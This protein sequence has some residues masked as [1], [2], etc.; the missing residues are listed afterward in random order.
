VVNL[1]FELFD[2]LLWCG[3]GI[4]PYAHLSIVSSS[5]ELIIMLASII[6]EILQF[7]I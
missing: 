2:I 5:R 3:E 4:P 1:P 6:F 7:D